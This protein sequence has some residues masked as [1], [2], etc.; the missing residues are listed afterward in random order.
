MQKK[1]FKPKEYKAKHGLMIRAKK[2]KNLIFLAWECEGFTVE[3]ERREEEEGRRKKRRRRNPGLEVWNSCL[4]ISYSCLELW[5]GTFVWICWLGN[6]PNSFFVYVWVRKTLTLQY[7]C[8][9]ICLS[10]FWGWF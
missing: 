7:M 3:K 1:N 5:F 8:I 4:E 6:Y 10:Q 9:L 2:K